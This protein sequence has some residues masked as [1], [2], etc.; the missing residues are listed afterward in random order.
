[1]IKILNKPYFLFL[2]VFLISFLIRLPAIGTESINPDAVNWHYRCQ[3]FANGLKYFQFEKTYPHYHPGVTLCYLMAFP[4]EVY[5][6]ITGQVY[7]ISTYQNF[8]VLNTYAV[9]IF[10]SFLISLIAVLLQKKNGLIFSVLLNIEPFF[11]GNSR[12][13]HL[14]T[15]VTL[16]LF[17]AILFLNKFFDEKKELN[18]YLSSLCFALAFLTKSVSIVFIVLALFSILL[19]LKHGRLKIFSQFLVSTLL[20][21]FLIFPAM[22]VAPFETFTRIF[23]EAD[24]VGV[25]T[26]HNQF[27]LGEFYD[28][29]SN[30]GA[31]FYPVV[32]LVKFSPLF[33]ISLVIIFF[34]ILISIESHLKTYKLN[35]GKFVDYLDQNRMNFLLVLFY[36]VYLLL[37]FYSSKK[38]DRYL[39]VLVP[40]V[41]YFISQKSGDYI[42]RAF[43]VLGFVNIVSLITFYPNLFY[44]YSPVLFSYENVNKLVGQKTFGGGVFDLRDYLTNK[45]GEKNLGFYDVKPMETV[46]PNSK[47]FDIRETSANKID[48]VILSVNEKLPEKYQDRF[49]KTESFYLYDIPA[50]DIY[51][52]K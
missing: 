42:K 24:R 35:L 6:Q 1:M 49:Q 16:L 51:L 23:K 19:F 38:V 3:Q 17:T 15:L 32:T 12:I 41:I 36:G 26:G 18:L 45:Y 46:Y 43:L 39:L 30:P 37:I 7:N 48:I 5:K 47:V 4:T 20:F 21:I 14:D 33:N 25:R 44:Y 8:N 52:K 2:T 9:V 27:F 11:Y 34:S 10:N 13:I 40:A 50:Y 28:E 31:W 29:D 22:W